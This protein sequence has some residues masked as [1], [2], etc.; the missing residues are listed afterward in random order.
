MEQRKKFTTENS[1]PV[2]NAVCSAKEKDAIR[3][4]SVF[5]G[6]KS[7]SE[8]IHKAAVNKILCASKV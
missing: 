3:V 8:I 7:A 5:V 4:V 6:H 1:P 2:H